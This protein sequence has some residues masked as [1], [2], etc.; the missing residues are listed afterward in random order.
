MYVHSLV[1]NGVGN[2]G[3]GALANVIRNSTSLE[4]LW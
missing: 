2:A 3:A 1:G 4:E